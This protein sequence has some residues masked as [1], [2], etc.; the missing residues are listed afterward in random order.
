MC[1]AT[2]MKLKPFKT[3]LTFILFIILALFFS[4]SPLLRV[5]KAVGLVSGEQE[6]GGVVAPKP[7]STPRPSA[8]KPTAPAKSRQTVPQIE[9]VLVPAGTFMMGSPDELGD[10]EERPQHRVTVQ[11]FYMGK[12]EVTQA[13]YRAVMGTNPSHFKGDNLP[14]EN[15]SWN[16]AKEF[17]R[18]LSQMTGKEY[19][20]PSEA[21]WEYACRAGTATAFAFGDSISSKQ[22]NF[23]GYNG[24]Y[25]G[26]AKGVNRRKTTQVGSFQ[27]NGW[28]L[29]DMH[30]N[31]GEWVE[32]VSHENY[33]GAPADGSAW[34]SGGNSSNRVARGGSWA[35]FANSI[36]SATR[37]TPW[38]TNFRYDGLGFRVALSARS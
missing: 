5:S 34:L 16:D 2:N 33:N 1:L 29:Y 7:R 36:L 17:C 38:D 26:A 10:D 27:P 37:Y 18:K 23:D 30:G 22:A 19:R 28:G 31:V 24:P 20:L 25:G 4:H 12:Y 15:V 11:S 3:C 35:H 32:D 6:K 8:R 9:M 13:Q 21:E 14:V